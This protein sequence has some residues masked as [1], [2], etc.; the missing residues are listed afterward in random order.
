MSNQVAAKLLGGKYEGKEVALDRRIV[1]LDTSE[2]CSSNIR[3][4]DPFD[5]LG[6]SGLVDLSTKVK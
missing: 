1:Q 2:T 6:K 5:F 4:L 3:V